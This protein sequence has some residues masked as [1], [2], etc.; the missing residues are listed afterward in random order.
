MKQVILSLTLL[1][2]LTA[3]AQESLINYVN[4]FIG[5]GG[6]GHTF[7]G[8]T[9]PFGMVQLSPDTRL[10]G[11]DG[12]GGYHYT[13]EVVYGFSHT[14][15]SGT[16]VS[17]YGDVLL[18]PFTGAVQFNNGADGEAGYSSPFDKGTEIAQPNY[19]FA[20]LTDD[21]IEVEL[22]ATERTGLHQYTFKRNGERQILIDLIHRDKVTDAY[23]KQVNEY[24]I[25][26]Y[27]HSD[28]WARQQ[29]LYFVIR[30]NQ[31]IQ[32]IDFQINKKINKKISE[33]K[34]TAIKAA[35]NFGE[36]E[37]ELMAQVAISAVDVEGARKNLDAEFADWN[38]DQTKKEGQEK[39][40]KQLSK[41]TVEDDDRDKK[42][43]FYTALYHNM[44]APNLYMDVDGRYRGTDLEVHQSEGHTHYTIFSLWDTYRATHPLYTIIEPERTNDF[45][46]TF[47]KHYEQGGTLP[48]WE[49]AANYTE[50]M[51][52][53]HAVPVISD[54]YM[55]GIRGYDADKALE[56]MV[57]S[58]NEERLGRKRYHEEGF[59]SG[60]AVAESVSK[61][62]EYAYD[63]WTIAVM[64]ETMGEREVADD[65]YASAQ[66]YKNV[67]D[68][69][70]GFMRARL[71]NRWFYPF[72]PSE[73]N[74]NYTEA[75]AW[76]YSYYV[77][78]DIAGWMDA[79]GGEAKLEA[80]LDA[81]FA[82]DS[83]TTGRDQADMTGLI[84]QYVHGNEPSHH[85][86]YL[87]NYVGKAHKTQAYVQRIMDEMYSNAPD[88]L[89]GNED[90]GQMS[91][92]LVMSAMGFYPVAPGSVDYAIG[93]PWLDK[94]TIHQENGNAFT[95]EANRADEADIYV[96]SVSLNDAPH[97]PTYITHA[98]ITQGG[99][100]TFNLAARPNPDYGKSLADRPMTKID[101]RE[102]VAIPAV[103]T[104]DKAFPHSTKITLECV[105][106]DADI[107]YTLNDSK[108]MSYDAPFDIKED[109]KLTV[110]AT[111]SGAIDSKKATSEFLK[112]AEFRDIKLFTEYADHYSAGGDMALVDYIRGGE[113]FRTGAWQ[114]YHGVDLVAVIDL[115]EKQSISDISTGFLQDENSWIF[116]PTE[117]EFFTSKNGKKFKSAGKVV[118]DISPKEKGSIIKNY[119]VETSGKARYIKVVAKNR[120]VCPP[121]HKGAGG[122]CWIFVDEVG[123][124]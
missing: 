71:N 45:I 98:D 59:L 120:G 102:V 65:F 95:I 14:H 54:A 61:T 92:W 108:P 16:G 1:L 109:T 115:G 60:E 106:P 101:S 118:T 66:Y 52:G 35:L 72:E 51:I 82:A 37:G 3:N 81:I 69:S 15:L 68:P 80:H 110:W 73:V 41:I 64:A 100:L 29:F 43:V 8:A 32:N 103:V 124:R 105:T 74:F 6:H 117:V 9:V 25:E 47:L 91:A 119:S 62:L 83:K 23:L 4:P 22:T 53:Y 31:P 34:N 40:E 107:F 122:K 5:T 114:G 48:M 86:A 2:T 13:D 70:T 10:E 79:L 67:F 7:P 28:A 121:Y 89:S 90:C 57:S 76:Q 56:A 85:I 33:A 17:D 77:P 116:M 96:Q 46:Q 36:M 12:C 78:Q 21:D 11:W 30:F 123:V 44:I 18:M 87:Y 42:T 113:D 104:G 49:L 94:V 88:G 84:G 24:E 93:S 58:A 63:D 99:T 20:H 55:K 50:C 97:T 38:F 75:N 27:R 111:K 112:M 26:G 19:Y 39:W